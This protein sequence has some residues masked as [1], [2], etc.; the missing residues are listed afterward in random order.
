MTSADETSYGDNG[1]GYVFGMIE[2][3]R[4]VLELVHPKVLDGLGQRGEEGDVH[5]WLVVGTQGGW[6]VENEMNARN[7]DIWSKF[8]QWTRCM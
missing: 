6:D 4:G 7:S 8:Y 2:G 5:K 1:R 3:L